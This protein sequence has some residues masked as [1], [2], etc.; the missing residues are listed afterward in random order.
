MQ[1]LLHLYRERNGDPGL[2]A[3]P[4][5][6]ISNASFLAAALAAW[7]LARRRG[8]LTAS[9]WTLICWRGYPSISETKVIAR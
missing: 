8:A 5:N 2:W 6:A 1:D 7:A 3:E 9:T 4:F